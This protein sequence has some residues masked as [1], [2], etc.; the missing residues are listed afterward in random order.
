MCWE[1]EVILEDEQYNK[2]LHC[3]NNEHKHDFWEIWTANSS[4][5]LPGKFMLM[6]MQM[7]TTQ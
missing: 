1:E 5:M 6:D 3:C 2:L 4:E 7:I